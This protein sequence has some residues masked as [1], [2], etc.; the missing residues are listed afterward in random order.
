MTFSV[1]RVLDAIKGI[2]GRLKISSRKNNE[3]PL[4]FES[5]DGNSVTVLMPMFGTP[6]NYYE[7][8]GSP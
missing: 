8:E 5:L 4:K 3:A 2:R 6:E 7:R 1:D